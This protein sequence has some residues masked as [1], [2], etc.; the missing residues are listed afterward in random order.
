MPRTIRGRVL[1]A[2]VI[3]I[4]GVI[5]FL[6]FRPDKL[7]ADDPIDESL[8]DAFAVATTT[9]ETSE[10]ATALPSPTTVPSSTVASTTPRSTTSSSSTSTVPA[11]STTASDPVTIA[12]GAIFGIDHRAGGTATVYRRGDDHILR[13]EDDTDIQNGPDLH[14]WFLAAD[15]YQGGIP[16]DYLYLGL[17]KG[18]VGGQNY[19]LPDE[20]DPA[21]HRFVLV[22]CDRFSVPFTGAALDN[23]SG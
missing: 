21:V 20:Y 23:H 15:N 11:T 22:W 2:A 17:L 6:L 1:A 18:N 7:V 8:D 12:R 4:V 5:A 14:V 10:T 3:A 19:Q 16:E 9:R 13:F